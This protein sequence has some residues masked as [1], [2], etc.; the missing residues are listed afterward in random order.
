MRVHADRDLRSHPM[1]LDTRL[2]AQ[3]TAAVDDT[4]VPPGL[5][6]AALA[7]GR[8][9]RRRRAL[10]GVA[11]VAAAVVGGV[12]L[13][14]DAGPSAR[15]VH[16]AEGRSSTAAALAWAR[17][18]PEGPAPALPFFGE[19][20][21]LWSGG[22]RHDVPDEVNRTVAPRVVDGGWL[23]F[24]GQDEDDIADVGAGPRRQPARP[25]R[26]AAA[27]RDV[28]RARSRRLARRAARRLPGPRRRPRHDGVVAGPAPS[29]VRRAGR[30][31]DRGQDDRLRRRWPGLRGGALR[32]G[33]R[34]HLAAA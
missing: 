14:P 32:V 33:V 1:T 21:D 16:P 4:T 18:L 34:R 23:V 15:D 28:R 2:H 24:V 26:P 7:G 25:P 27:P 13:L 3:L 11:G 30:L 6:Q 8:S 12:L 5:A 20:G 19:G 9:R 17:S 22:Q 31:R 10:G 29:R